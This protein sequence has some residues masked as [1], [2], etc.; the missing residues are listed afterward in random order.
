[1]KKTLPM[2]KEEAFRRAESCIVGRGYQ[3]TGRWAEKMHEG[4]GQDI[5][6]MALTNMPQTRL[7][8]WKSGSEWW[9]MISTEVGTW[10]EYPVTGSSFTAEVKPS[11][12][13]RSFMLPRIEQI[14]AQVRQWDYEIA[15]HWVDKAMMKLAIHHLKTFHVHKALSI[16]YTAVR[17]ELDAATVAEALSIV[18]W[19]HYKTKEEMM[20]SARIWGEVF[21]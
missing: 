10:G 15:S 13:R 5:Y 17:G 19:K 16:L 4:E 14:Q 21:I 9:A 12:S 6:S 20:I 1:M 11:I 2:T 8:V 3:T 7:V 18:Q